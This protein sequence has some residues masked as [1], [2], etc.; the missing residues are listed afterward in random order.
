[1]K[2][3]S[4]KKVATLGVLTALSLIAFMLESLLPPLFI[5]GAKIGVANVFTL[6]CI[7]LL[8]P[9]DGIILVVA[10][11]VLSGVIVGS[12]S[13]MIYSLVAGLSAAVIMAV[14]YRFFKNSL[15]IVAISV[16]G[17]AAHNAAQCIVFF[18]TTKSSAVFCYMPY[19]LMF[20][21]FSGVAVGVLATLAVRYGKS[22]LKSAQEKR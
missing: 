17:A 3:F 13:S 11:T 20:G 22:V 15:S 6:V 4:A 19:L 8:S 12:L 18:L 16:V 9:M 7:C 2:T 10:R 1:M 21:I 14:L 5:P